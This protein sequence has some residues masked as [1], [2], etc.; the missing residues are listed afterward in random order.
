MTVG[1]VEPVPFSCID[2]FYTYKSNI[3][4][5]KM[6]CN[7]Y[8]SLLKT[9]FSIETKKVQ[10]YLYKDSML[11]RVLLEKAEIRKCY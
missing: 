2:A 11:G 1:I 7:A 9:L 5:D 4:K 3:V 10:T 6:V 8:P